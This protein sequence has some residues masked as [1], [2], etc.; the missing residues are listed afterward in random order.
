MKR[1]TIEKLMGDK[2]LFAQVSK[3]DWFCKDGVLTNRGETLK[4]FLIQVAEANK[5]RFDP[6]ETFVVFKDNY[7]LWGS[8][9]DDIRIC[10]VKTEDVLFIIIWSSGFD[11]NKGSSLLFSRK[12]GFDGPLVEGTFDDVLGYFRV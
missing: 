2:T 12:N 11:A 9:Y 8:R 7:P 3:A 1:I 4:N 10:D 5:G 6:A